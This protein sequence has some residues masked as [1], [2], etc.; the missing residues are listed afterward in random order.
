MEPASSSASTVAQLALA[1]LLTQGRDIVPIPGTRS[2][3]RL[4]EDVAAAEVTLDQPHLDRIQEILPRGAWNE[5]Y[6]AAHM[7]RG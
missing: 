6:P 2:P 5:R 4:E 1:W 3:V 7:P